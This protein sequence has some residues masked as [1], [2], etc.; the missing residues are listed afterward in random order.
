[1]MLIKMIHKNYA[2]N[3]R[4]DLQSIDEQYRTSE[5]TKNTLIKWTTDCIQDSIKRRRTF[6][7]HDAV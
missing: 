1:M 3:L 7:G 6:T 4:Q 2:K 5:L